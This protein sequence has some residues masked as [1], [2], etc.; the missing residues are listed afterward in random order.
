MT[1]VKEMKIARNEREREMI[2]DIRRHLAF[3]SKN[4]GA[5]PDEYI[6]ENYKQE[7]RDMTS[8]LRWFC[9]HGYYEGEEGT[10]QVSV[11]HL[12]N[13]ICK[14]NGGVAK[15]TG[16]IAGPRLDGWTR[17]ERQSK[18]ML[19]ACLI[20]ALNYN[21]PPEYQPQWTLPKSD[22]ANDHPGAVNYRERKK[23]EKE[24]S[25]KAKHAE[26]MRKTRRTERLEKESKE[27][28]KATAKQRK[29]RKK[30]FDEQDRL[31]GK[32]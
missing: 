5:V 8:K 21:P 24:E 22:P 6:S 16:I 15:L 4:I 20:R 32:K 14:K 28:L 19:K 10:S 27:R 18:D 30:H 25:K 26:L 7:L 9:S 13:M 1:E 12:F 23:L 29:D 11:S 3:L 2:T 17:F 31:R